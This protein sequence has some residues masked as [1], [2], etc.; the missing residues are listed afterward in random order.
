MIEPATRNPNRITAVPQNWPQ[1]I[2]RNQTWVSAIAAL[3][4]LVVLY[5][6]GATNALDR[7]AIDFRFNML[8]R[9]ASG[10]IVIVALDQQ[11]HTE[12]QGQPASRMQHAA[13][14]NNLM[15]AGAK[16]VGMK[17]DFH[18]ETGEL[19]DTALLMAARMTDGRLVLPVSTALVAGFSS[20][21]IFRQPFDDLSKIAN[22]GSIHLEQA[23]DGH[24]H[25]YRLIHAWR[26]TF[27][28]SFAGEV[29][30]KTS[31]EHTSL[32]L[33]YGIDARSI[34]RISYV[35]VLNNTFSRADIEGKFIF[36]GTTEGAPGEALNVP[37]YGTLSGVEIHALAGE[38][39]LQ[40]D[41]LES[42]P[43]PTDLVLA[44][45]IFIVLTWVLLSLGSVSGAIIAMTSAVVVFGLSVAVQSVYALSIPIAASLLGIALAYGVAIYS[46]LNTK[47]QD[48]FKSVFEAHESSELMNAII[49]TNFDSI[50]VFDEQDR[51]YFINP[52]A[53]RM[54]NWTVESA[55]GRERNAVLRLP[56]DFA[57]AEN[58]PHIFETVITRAD[59]NELDVE[60]A[61]TETVLAPSKARFERRNQARVYRI[62][63]FRDI[64]ERKKA[65]ASMTDAAERAMQAER[66][67]SEFIGN[68]SHELRAPLNSVIGFSEV[69]KQELFGNIGNPRYKEYAEDIFAS[70]THLMS[71]IHDL[72]EVS[73]IA[74]GK[75][76]LTDTEID[77]ERMFAE[78]LQVVRCYPN[79]SK[80]ILSASMRPGCPD[81]IADKR[82]IKQILINLLSNAVKFTH[83]GG[84]VRLSAAPSTKGGVEI[85]VSDDGIGIPPE[86]MH[87][88]TDA[89]HQIDHADH[90]KHAGTGLG[91][92]IVQSLAQLHDAEIAVTSTVNS[93]TQVRVIFPPERNGAAPNVI[94]LE[95]GEKN[96]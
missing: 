37:V 55:L 39:I 48:L 93:G 72:L 58:E 49:A 13:V 65:A 24:I 33:D 66:L 46:R 27:I 77:M 90:R 91:L 60:M 70:G 41:F 31:L 2:S 74:S 67:K 92:H 86:E 47:S 50:V 16:R 14:I 3:I 25:D 6:V 40:G 21:V 64:S 63:T 59:G 79:A 73:Q 17:F 11:S 1:R 7:A 57:V 89:F 29:V 71:I 52:V 42:L 45:C 8:E 61:I 22:L 43:S 82:A 83:E 44:I 51:V 5:A 68:M 15:A 20:E 9:S 95:I 30:K 62:Y 28:P 23:D 69:I 34:P 87:R 10:D 35:D 53:A 19:A 38:M 32:I 18:A 36:V 81:L 76:E 75:V 84:G 12:L 88:I 80:K 96:R 54:L 26:N 94:Q 56:E 85:M 4:M 78:C